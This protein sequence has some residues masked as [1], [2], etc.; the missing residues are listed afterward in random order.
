MSTKFV[1]FTVVWLVVFN[2][3]GFAGKARANANHDVSLASSL[4]VQFVH[5]ATA[6]NINSFWTTIDHPLTNG[7]PNAIILVTQN[8]NPGASCACVYDDH[9]IGV[10]Y[11]GG[12]WAIFN[13]DGAAMPPN[14]TFNVIIPTAGSNA[15]VHKAASGNI[16]GNNTVIDNS[17]TNNNPN[18]IVMVTPNYNPGGVGG[19]D[20]IHNIGVF[21]NGGKWAIFNQDSASMPVDAAFNVLVLAEDTGVFVHKATSGNI[22]FNSTVI[23]NPLLN[24]YPNALVFVTPNWNPGGSGGTYLDKSIG[25]WYTGT[26]WA[27]FTQDGTSMPVDAAFN[28]L[29]LAPKFDD[30]VHTATSANTVTHSTKIDNALTNG[31]PNAIV[32]ATPNWNP[33]GSSGTYLNHNFG[34]WYTSSSG[35]QWRIFNQDIADMPIGAAFNVFVPNP[36][37]SVF[38]HKATASNTFANQTT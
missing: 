29:V 35:G 33:G 12:K 37:A 20:N 4:R 21:Y 30:F 25:V 19:T 14:A 2:L 27:V 32:F 8:W 28:I 36:D 5:V 10:W 13:M 15:F 22:T 31:N 6:D 11:T 38:V 7:N 24:D 18:A 26:K 9:P 16:Y 23:D 3:I 17:L 1:R 34:M